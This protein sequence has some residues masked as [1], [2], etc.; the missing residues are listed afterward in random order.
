MFIM[1]NDG[2]LPADLEKDAPLSGET[3]AAASGPE[4]KED[5][6]DI[7]R[8]LRQRKFLYGEWFKENGGQ[9]LR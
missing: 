5:E 2:G 3:E 9:R 6:G 7:L 1:G 4:P 8:I